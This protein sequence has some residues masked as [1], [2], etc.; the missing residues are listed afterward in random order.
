[1]DALPLLVL[2]AVCLAASAFLYWRHRTHGH[3]EDAATHEPPRGDD[4]HR[5]SS[6]PAGPGAEPMGVAGPGESTPA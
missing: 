2:A 5:P 6:A 3:P 1:M 4:R